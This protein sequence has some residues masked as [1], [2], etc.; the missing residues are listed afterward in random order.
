MILGMS[1]AAFTLL[2]VILSLIGIGAGIIV[3]FGMFSSSRLFGMTATF[4]AATALT[5]VTG[6]F[7]PRDQLLPSHIVGI[8]TLVALAIAILALYVYH[9]AESWRWLYVVGSVVALYLKVFVGVVQA[10]F[11]G[12]VVERAGAETI[13]PAVY[14]RA[15]RRDGALCRRWL[16]WT[17]GSCFTGG[18]NRRRTGS[19]DDVSATGQSQWASEVHFEC[20]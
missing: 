4:L 13:G 5:S 2:H 8:I 14:H 19:T 6:F 7:F 11:E 10:F 3:V 9:L 20:T 15:D 1:T 16:W 12:A 17:H 18:W